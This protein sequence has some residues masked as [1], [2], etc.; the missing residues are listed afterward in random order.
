MP[1]CYSTH[2]LL[3]DEEND[4]E[5]STETK[6]RHLFVHPFIFSFSLYN[7]FMA[8]NE[9]S[10]KGSYVSVDIIRARPGGHTLCL[11]DTQLEEDILLNCTGFISDEDISDEDQEVTT[12]HNHHDANQSEIFGQRIV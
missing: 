2:Q 8:C 10:D 12:R 3:I 7:K 11:L 6:L 5:N 4:P 1:L 9:L